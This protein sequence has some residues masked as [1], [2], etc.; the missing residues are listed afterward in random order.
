MDKRDKD[1]EYEEPIEK[2]DE[3]EE[4]ED[5]EEELRRLSQEEIKAEVRREQQRAQ[6]MKRIVI[7]AVIL[8]AAYWVINVGVDAWCVLKEFGQPVFARAQIE[9]QS[10][11]FYVYEGAGYSFTANGALSS[12]D[13]EDAMATQVKFYLLGNQVAE[14]GRP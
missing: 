3:Y 11:D 13:G 1:Y 14:V 12:P 5:G 9:R 4:A 2:Q 10:G 7:V 8:L 6:K